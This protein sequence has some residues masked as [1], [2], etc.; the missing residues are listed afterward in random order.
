VLIA[1][2]SWIAFDNTTRKY[3]MTITQPT[4][5]GVYIIKTTAEIA[6]ADPATTLNRVHF[7]TF[8]MT[9]KSD[10]INTVLIDAALNAMTVKVYQAM[11]T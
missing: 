3:S 11:E 6:Q 2:P 4:D 9:V 1:K 8:T 7:E 10:C 5:V